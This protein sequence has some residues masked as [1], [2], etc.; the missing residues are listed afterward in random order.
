MTVLISTMYVQATGINK[1]RTWGT[2]IE[3]MTLPHLLQ[4]SLYTY[5]VPRQQWMCYTPSTLER[6]ARPVYNTH[7]DSV[8]MGMYIHHTTTHFEV[9]RAIP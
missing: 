4:T 3:M 6:I 7:I 9:V 8:Q 1:N 5:N 2:E